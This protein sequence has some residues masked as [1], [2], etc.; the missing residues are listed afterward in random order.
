MCEKKIIIENARG[1]WQRDA[2]F[3]YL[4]IYCVV[5]FYTTYNII[6]GPIKY[7]LINIAKRTRKRKITHA[8]RKNL[9]EP[10]TNKTN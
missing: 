9:D 6:A 8:F 10:I 2:L 1:F 7:N 4:F 3:I 5:T